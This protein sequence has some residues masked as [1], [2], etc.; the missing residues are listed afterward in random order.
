MRK[1]IMWNLMS[2]DGFEGGP[3]RDISWHDDVWG[4]EREQL[5][6]EQGGRS[7]RSFSGASHM[8]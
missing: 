2:L 3:N 5:S 4:P 6:I 7:A 8:S 1:Q